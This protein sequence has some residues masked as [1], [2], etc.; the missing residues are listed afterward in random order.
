M[1]SS[2]EEFIATLSNI[3]TQL[4]RSFAIFIYIFGI[5][6][7]IL[8]I[9]ALSQRLFRF[10]TCAVLFMVSSLANFI[11]IAAGLTSK[12]FSGWSDDLTATNRFFCKLRTFILNVARLISSHLA[13]SIRHD[14][15]M[16]TRGK[17]DTFV[18]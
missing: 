5:V 11:A 12:I 8:N 7:N 1:S 3:T 10:N 14:R 9:L 17:H 2:D 18:L 16:V 15:S 13:Y 6:G 4:N